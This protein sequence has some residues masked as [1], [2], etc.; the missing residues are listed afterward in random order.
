MTSVCFCRSI[1]CR[2]LNGDTDRLRVWFYT[3]SD[4]HKIIKLIILVY[5]IILSPFVPLS[6]GVV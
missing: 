3:I 2:G 1:D 5:S 4:R 6:I